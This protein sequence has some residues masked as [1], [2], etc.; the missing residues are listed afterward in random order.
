MLS[1]VGLAHLTAA[2]VVVSV[3]VLQADR[4]QRD[5][6]KPRRGDRI[7]FGEGRV[8]FEAPPGFTPLS[9]AEIAKVFPG[10]TPP[11]EAVG[12]SAR[13]TTITYQLTGAKVVP[14]QL[15]R[16]RKFMAGEIEKGFRNVKWTVNH[17]ELLR[18]REWARM[19]FTTENSPGPQVFHIG[20]FT[21]FDGNRTVMFMFN[22]LARDLPR[23]EAPLREAVA[24]IDV[25]T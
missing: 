22:A 17:V 18:G 6:L 16:F 3:C 5:A 13:V 20:L 14:G 24:S 8:S 25:K 10:P 21:P 7:T 23:V 1:N 19:E 12:D 4:Q 9:A 2:L 11:S 15:D